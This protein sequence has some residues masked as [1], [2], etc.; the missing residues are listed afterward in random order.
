MGLVGASVER[1]LG[2][3]GVVAALK[4]VKAVANPRL[5]AIPAKGADAASG[6]FAAGLRLVRAGHNETMVPPT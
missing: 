2:L 1:S 5:A 6:V 4:A 3:G